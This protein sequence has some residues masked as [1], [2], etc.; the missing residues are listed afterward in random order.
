MILLECIINESFKNLDH[1][2]TSDSKRITCS[3]TSWII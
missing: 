2:S 3:T 1:S